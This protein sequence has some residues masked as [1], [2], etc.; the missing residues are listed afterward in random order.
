[1]SL[2]PALLVEADGGSRG[3]PGVAGYGALVKDAR[4]GE[5]LAERALPLGTASNNVA[6]YSGLVAGLEAVLDLG[7]ATDAAVEVRMDS[8]LVV[9][10][11]CGRWKIKHEDMRRLALQ[12]RA[13]VDRIQAAGGSVRFTWIPR[14]R[15][16]AADAL[17]NVAMDGRTVHRDLARERAGSDG[18][19]TAEE[20][21]AAAGPGTGQVFGDARVPLTD[22]FVSDETV[23]TLEGQTRLVLVR[24]GVTDFTQGHRLDGRGGA[25]PALNATGLAQARAA[26]V[27]VRRLLDRSDPGR[28][29][30][31]SSSLRRARQTGQVVADHL[32]VARE[33]DADWDEQGFGSWDGRA[34]PDLVRDSAAD[35]ARLR[36]DLDFAPPGGETRRELDRRVGAALGRAISRGGTVVVATHRVV[37]MSVLGRLLGIDHSRAWSVATAPTSLTA[38]EV[39]ADG[40][41]QVEFVNDTHHLY[42]PAFAE[43][44]A[45][46]EAQV[47]ILD[48]SLEGPPA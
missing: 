29:T 33:E 6:E 7:L 45:Q 18:P 31:V 3:N 13:L 43:D 42:D 37:L 12:A 14:E 19:G 38:V 9:E 47:R 36:H 44:L 28:V 32:G 20:T 4:T 48:S 41:V 26:A 23:P 30:V 24:H 35:L 22:V 16:G 46:L 1:M 39:W 10:Q 25:D 11:M 8:K 27:A 5:L 34:M 17:S 2:R 21:P 15:N 40:G